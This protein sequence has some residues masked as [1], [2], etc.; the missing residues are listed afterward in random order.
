MANSKLTIKWLGSGLPLRS[1][2]RALRGP[3]NAADTSPFKN[4]VLEPKKSSKILTFQEILLKILIFSL[5]L[6]KI[7]PKTVPGPLEPAFQESILDS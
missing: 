2:G 7:F 6:P 1:E 4:I 3:R 5:N